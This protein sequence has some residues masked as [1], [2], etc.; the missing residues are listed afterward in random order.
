MI[1]TVYFEKGSNF[2]NVYNLYQW[3]YGQS[4]EIKGLNIHDNVWVQFSMNASG[5]NA[6]PVVTEVNDG[7]I[8]ANIPAFVFE[9]ETMQNY[10]AYAFVYVSNADSGE[11]V[12]VI[13]LNIKAR[14]KPEDYVY[15]EP[16]KKRYELLE[17]R[18][19]ELEENGVPG[20]PSQD[21]TS[22]IDPRRI[23]D[24]YYKESAIVEIL[25]ETNTQSND[26]QE[27]LIPAF[28]ELEVGKEYTIVY[29]GNTYLSKAQEFHVEDI[30][31][32]ILG[33]GSHLGLDGN[34]E[35]FAIA[36]ME[37]VLSGIDFSGA[38]DITIA[39][40]DGTEKINTIK[41]E[42]FG[43]DWLPKE[44]ENK[45]EI[46]KK[47]VINVTNAN[48]F[49]EY[50]GFDLGLDQETRKKIVNKYDSLT[51]MLDGVN[52]KLSHVKRLEEDGVVYSAIYTAI[53]YDE[54]RI[55]HEGTVMID[56]GKN[57]TAQILLTIGEHE[58][59]VS[60]VEKS[61]E[62]I[63]KKFIPDYVL[64]DE[65]VDSELS[66]ESLNPVK[67][68]V[69]AEAVE[70]LSEE[71]VDVKS[72]LSEIE[73][74]LYSKTDNL[75]DYNSV[76][77]GK[78]P[79]APIGSSY[80]E[81]NNLANWVTSNYIPVKEGKQYALIKDNNIANVI[82]NFAY[83]K[84]DVLVSR[85]NGSELNNPFTIP[86][87]VD[88]V[89]I[90]L[91]SSTLFTPDKTSVKEYTESMDLNW[92][93]Y[94]GGKKYATSEEVSEI[95][96]NTN[97][98]GVYV[99]GSNYY[100][101][102]NF[103]DK[104]LIRLFKQEGP[105]NLFQLSAIYVGKVSKDGVVID[106]TIA[107]HGTDI[108]GPISIWRSG[109]D[110]GGKWSGGYHNVTVDG[111]K[112]PTAEQQSLDV[113][114]NGESVVG[115]NGLHYGKVVAVCI[116]NLYFPQSVTSTDLSTA[117]QAIKETREYYLD[118]KMTVRVSHKYVA[119][120]RISVYY[121]MQAVRLG[122]DSVLLPNNEMNFNFADM[123]DNLYLDKA[124]TLIAMK[125]DSWNYDLI[126][127]EIGL[128]KYTHTQGTGSDKYGYLPVSVRKVYF[129]LINGSSE[130]TSIANGKTLT[131]EGI[132]N[133]YPN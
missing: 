111:V 117:T 84:N 87:G 119:D 83:Y 96:K 55:D 110:S 42:Y 74:D 130:F 80:T 129:T 1:N 5:G 35:P 24:M 94:G 66:K 118:E 58:L 40:Y 124:E 8:T 14:P 70:K 22:P 109:V 92:H 101:F 21:D 10:N 20:G 6:I 73:N 122:F 85:E 56:M 113:R 36:I 28:V 4:L 23:P 57:G 51:L 120:T 128:G 106:E 52:V 133:I 2:A 48:S 68:K 13:K 39:I 30:T 9:K 54:L 105:N 69:V 60:H 115:V 91:K 108:V 47:Q 126:L 77:F 46:F 79:T 121:G 34:D 89:Y 27:F 49:G 12:K 62:K 97:K 104:A 37:S 25:P 82:L 102:V 123:T 19:K 64:T 112:Y 103:G 17:E 99:D 76:A 114:V 59:E 26:E 65:K 90:Y 86:E 107:T 29:N 32:V 131:W 100:H 71:I 88:H 78:V 127:K 93:P 7:V 98:Y 67:N 45:V 63:P 81:L 11:T 33:N 125:N 38:K 61:I 44:K 75:F 43:F 31:V 50:Y 53:P 16:E 95:A 116:N 132:Y 3:D 41:D 15:T 72:D 18:V